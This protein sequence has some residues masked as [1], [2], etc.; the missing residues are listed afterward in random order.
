MIDSSLAIPSAVLE[1][2]KWDET[3][4]PR[5]NLFLNTSNGGIK[6]EVTL[7]GPTDDIVRIRAES[8]HNHVKMRIVSHCPSG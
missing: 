2:S 5:P 1:D 6:G 7:V 4:G 3:D 8:I